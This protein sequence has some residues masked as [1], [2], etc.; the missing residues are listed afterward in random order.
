MKTINF[1]TT[2]SVRSTLVFTNQIIPDVYFFFATVGEEI[3]LETSD[4]SFDTTIRVVGPDAAIDLF[5]D[6][7]GAGFASRL[8]F[9]AADTGGYIVVVSSYD[10]NPPG[11]DYTLNFARGSTVH[12]SLS[13][14]R[15]D[16]MLGRTMPDVENPVKDKPPKLRH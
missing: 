9:T 8:V 11:G 6:D 16:S 7:G 3:R 5:N 12:Q 15:E 10:G 4:I 1:T 2:G 14:L 13:A